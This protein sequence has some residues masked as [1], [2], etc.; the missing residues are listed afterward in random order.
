MSVK[1]KI[2][3]K[4]GEIFRVITLISLKHPTYHATNTGFITT[5]NH[6]L[7]IKIVSSNGYLVVGEASAIQDIEF[8]PYCC[9]VYGET[10]TKCE[11]CK[12]HVS[13]N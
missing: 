7:G 13:F 1:E 4:K 5:K 8:C 12:N 6:E 2:S 3:V 11:H 9:V 10:F